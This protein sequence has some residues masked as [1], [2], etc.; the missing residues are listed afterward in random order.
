MTPEQ[1]MEV[2]RWML[3]SIG[4]IVEKSEAPAIIPMVYTGNVTSDNVKRAQAAVAA[5]Q[6]E[7]EAEELEG[8]KGWSLESKAVRYLAVVAGDYEDHI[9]QI[10]AH[11]AKDRGHEAITEGDVKDA[12]EQHWD[13][14]YSDDA[15]KI[16]ALTAELAEVRRQ[17]EQTREERDRHAKRV[18][19]LESE[20]RHVG[21][22]ADFM[23]DALGS[24]AGVVCTP[25]KG[26][27]VD[28]GFQQL[29][30]DLR[31]FRVKYNRA[32]RAI[33]EAVANGH[34][35]SQDF[36]IRQQDAAAMRAFL[37]SAALPAAPAPEGT[38]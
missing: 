5:P 38:E 7:S 24:I 9:E 35:T 14:Y 4:R 27:L 19:E 33:R 34:G 18:K 25:E 26:Y 15:D 36:L 23:R 6:P 30:S 21:S 8:T 3:D 1:R 28:G 32:V 16:A 17:H 20:G 29:A 31:D 11:L 22:I 13:R 37:K 10:A 2:V 12:Q